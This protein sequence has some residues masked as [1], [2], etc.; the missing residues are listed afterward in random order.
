VLSY[1]H[2]H[3][4]HSDLTHLSS[5]WKG[6]EKA[7]GYSRHIRAI[8]ERRFASS[9]SYVKREHESMKDNELQQCSKKEY[10]GLHNAVVMLEL[11]ER[12]SKGTP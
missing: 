8:D 9:S 2:L 12:K 5:F 10:F 7:T 1:L 6:K 11:Q 3:R 4:S